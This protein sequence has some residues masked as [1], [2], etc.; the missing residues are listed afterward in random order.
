MRTI[1]SNT[2][3]MDYF[4]PLPCKFLTAAR[5]LRTSVICEGQ[6]SELSLESVPKSTNCNLRHS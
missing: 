2:D 5:R 4:L 3:K 1:L 6:W